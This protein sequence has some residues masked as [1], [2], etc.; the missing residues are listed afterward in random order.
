MLGIMQ[1]SFA[2]FIAALVI[3][4]LAGCTT[5]PDIGSAVPP[6]TAASGSAAAEVAVPNVVGLDGRMAEQ[7]L[8][9]AGFPYA[10]DALV[11]L[12]VDWTVTAQS[13]TGVVPAGSKVV[14]TATKAD[15][16]TAKQAVAG[17]DAIAAV[18]K[19][20]GDCFT[21]LG[22]KAAPM[23]SANTKSSAPVGIVTVAYPQG[24][25]VFAIAVGNSGAILSS[26]TDA[27][28]TS[29]LAYGGC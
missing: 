9:G 12:P 18:Q 17:P 20:Y 11:V 16:T 27:A 22:V 28:T 19:N 3:T 29:A 13:L 1:R 24:S 4:I 26:V 5:G 14:L 25:L 10:F 6:T 21:K 2:L 15:K 8:R 23:Y 7:K